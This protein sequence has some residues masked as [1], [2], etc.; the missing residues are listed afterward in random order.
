MGLLKEQNNR[1]LDAPWDDHVTLRMG[2]RRAASIPELTV[3]SVLPPGS[4]D[5]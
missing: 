5:G 4:S 2:W 3:L 1:R